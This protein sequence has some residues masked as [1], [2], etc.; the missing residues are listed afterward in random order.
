MHGRVTIVQSSG[1]FS[2][3]CEASGLSY[4]C[5]KSDLATSFEARQGDMVEFAVDNDSEGLVCSVSLQS[6][7]GHGGRQRSTF[8]ASADLVPYRS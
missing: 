3:W 7:N 5:R 8:V 1:N 6:R 2:I 4:F